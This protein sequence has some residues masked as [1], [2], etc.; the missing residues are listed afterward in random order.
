MS[1]RCR[2]YLITPPEIADLAAFEAALGAALR[3]GDVACLQLRLKS[4]AG[5]PAPDEDVLAAARALL[6][7]C[8]EAGVAFLINDR[9]DLA[10][11]AGADGAHIGQTDGGVGAARAILGPEASIG[12]TCHA[13]RDLAIEAGEAGADYVAFGAF[14]PTL[15]KEAPHRAST[16]ILSW[17]R[18][19]TTLPSV[20]IGG[21][22]PENCAP[23]V[24]AGADFLAVSSAVWGAPDGP[25]AAVAAFNAAIDGALSA[26]PP[27]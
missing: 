16:D 5:A 1:E 17:W 4:R 6:P 3:G 21:I 8:R 11:A 20:A 23:L 9:P 2:L 25:A 15:T 14:F 7:V 27:E 12:V 18:F 26:N 13:S 22:T 19:A 10:H 24:S